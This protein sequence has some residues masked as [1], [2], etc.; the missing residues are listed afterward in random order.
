MTAADAWIGVGALRDRDRTRLRAWLPTNVAQGDNLV[1][2]RLPWALSETA[3]QRRR[4]GRVAVA[5]G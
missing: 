5:H 3:A 2:G 4:D 1:A